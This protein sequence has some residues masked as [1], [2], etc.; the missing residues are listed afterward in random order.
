MLTK[1]SIQFS[2]H[3]VQQR[4][5]E[6]DEL[7][8]CR[9]FTVWKILSTLNNGP[10]GNVDR[11]AL[12]T[13]NVRWTPAG[14]TLQ[15]ATDGTLKLHFCRL[16]CATH[17]CCI[18]VERTVLNKTPPSEWACWYGQGKND[19]PMKFLKQHKH[20]QT[21]QKYYVLLLDYPKKFSF[22]ADGGTFTH[23]LW[24]RAW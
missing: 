24:L 3:R 12:A 1:T 7:D 23:G 17:T 11:S 2:Q 6:S 9:L 19:G 20:G 10:R 13:S 5:P 21:V 8:W 16:T 4:K 18:G 15:A 14:I 22:I